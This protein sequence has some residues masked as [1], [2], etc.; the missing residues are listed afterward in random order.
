LAGF[1]VD[2]GVLEGWQIAILTLQIPSLQFENW[3]GQNRKLP[4]LLDTSIMMFKIC[5]IPRKWPEA[6][7]VPLQS[8]HFAKHLKD[9]PAHTPIGA[10]RHCHATTIPKPISAHRLNAE[11]QPWQY[12]IAG[13]FWMQ[14]VTKL[15]SAI[16]G[17]SDSHSYF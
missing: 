14:K 8:S 9:N 11:S 1:G 5:I 3:E 7:R 2:S 15:S 17:S 13:L 4:G 12:R 10:A 6:V 16:W